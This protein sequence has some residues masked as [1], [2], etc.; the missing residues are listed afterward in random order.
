MT[1]VESNNF[2]CSCERRGVCLLV[3]LVEYLTPSNNQDFFEDVS[4]IT[5]DE[6]KVSS[7]KRHKV[8]PDNSTVYELTKCLA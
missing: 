7:N 2:C 6:I 1:Q 3:H 5:S 8:F 4:R